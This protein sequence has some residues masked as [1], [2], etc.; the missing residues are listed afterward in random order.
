MDDTDAAL[1]PQSLD[2]LIELRNDREALVVER[3]PQYAGALLS[4]HR[5]SNT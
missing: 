3:K 4:T 2:T 1:E 5:L